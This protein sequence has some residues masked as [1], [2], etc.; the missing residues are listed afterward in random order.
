MAVTPVMSASVHI[1]L[2][3]LPLTVLHLLGLVVAE[4]PPIT[5]ELVGARI[6]RDTV[7]A[8]GLE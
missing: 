5:T 4:F 7:V 6:C 1:G 2:D 3:G 8:I